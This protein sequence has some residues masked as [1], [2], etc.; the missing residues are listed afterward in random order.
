MIQTLYSLVVQIYPREKYLHGMNLVLLH[1]QYSKELSMILVKCSFPSE[2]ITSPMPGA[3]SSTRLWG[4]VPSTN[5]S[6][7]L[8][9]YL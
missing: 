3:K 5:F 8:L 6:M 7:S 2:P 9:L 1:D 4:K